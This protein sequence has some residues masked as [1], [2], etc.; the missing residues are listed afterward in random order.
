MMFPLYMFLFVPDCYR[1][2][3]VNIMIFYNIENY[4]SGMAYTG[5]P[6][7]PSFLPN[8]NSCL[9]S[10][11]KSYQFACLGI[12]AFKRPSLDFTVSPKDVFSYLL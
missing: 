7:K 4:V 6:H 10:Q 5:I 2:S 12:K 1:Y 11:Y 3:K 9:Y 8:S